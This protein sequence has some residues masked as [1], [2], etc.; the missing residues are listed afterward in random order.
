[1]NM[2]ISKKKNQIGL[3]DKMS[4]HPK[5]LALRME[6]QGFNKRL[7]RDEY[8]QLFRLMSPVV[9]MYWT[10][11][12]NPPVIQHRA[13]F[14]D[15]HYNDKLRSR[16]EIVKGRFQGG[17]VGYVFFD[18][19]ELYIALYKKN[20]GKITPKMDEIINLIEHEGPIN[21][22]G[23]KE[24]LGMY[25]K[26]ITPILHK[27]QMAFIVFEDQ[28][29]VEWDRGW[30][31]FEREFPDINLTKYTFQSALKIIIERFQKL[32]IWFDVKMVETVYKLPKKLIQ[33]SIDE[34][35]QENKF[36]LLEIEGD[37]GY[38]SIEDYNLIHH[39]DLNQTTNQ[40]FCMNKNDFY[41]KAMEYILQKDFPKTTHEPMYY[42]LH[43]GEFIGA[44][45]GKF[46]IRPDELEDVIITKDIEQMVL[47]KDDII[48]AIGKVADYSVSPLKRFMGEKR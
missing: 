19:I 17:S 39:L 10:M 9:P 8:H 43:Q 48:K 47:R 30:Y 36:Q 40:I 16:R 37:T 33:V 5:I 23:M 28:R 3:K 14:S 21:V 26:D 15:F 46:R 34:L 42:L 1:M 38:I 4:L 44:V 31:V 2:I 25:V 41:V 18:E 12:G 24:V 6:R 27:L 45:Y 35:V 7:D 20:I 22:K 32:M 13:D 29:S 11:P